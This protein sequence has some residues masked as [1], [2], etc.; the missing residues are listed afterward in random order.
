[1]LLYNKNKPPANKI[2][3]WI[4]TSELSQPHEKL[5]REDLL[6]GELLI[7]TVENYFYLYPKIEEQFN[8]YYDNMFKKCFV[9]FDSIL[10]LKN[11]NYK[12][13][14]SP[15]FKHNMKNISD[16]KFKMIFDRVIRRPE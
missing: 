11:N 10:Y 16:D 8:Y 13:I 14:E 6:W 9:E 4:E 7:E 12:I 2:R 1:M 3:D 15:D 5:K